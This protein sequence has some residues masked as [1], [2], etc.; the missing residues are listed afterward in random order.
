M[1]SWFSGLNDLSLNDLKNKV[2]AAIP[3]DA[4]T[5][6]KLTLTTPELTAEREKI[7]QEEKRKEQVRD[8]L[9]HMYPWETRDEEREILVEECKEAVMALSSDDETFFGPYKM[10]HMK[11]DTSDSTGKKKKK[12]RN[13]MDDG[14][15][16]ADD[17]EDDDGVEIEE[18]FDDDDEEDDDEE[19]EEDEDEEEKAGDGTTK[20]RK[21]KEPTPESLE[22]LAKLEPLPP[23]LGD[24]DLDAHVGLIQKMLSVD[25]M[26]VERQSNLSGKCMALMN[27]GSLRATL[28]LW[29]FGIVCSPK[30]F[31]SVRFLFFGG[32]FLESFLIRQHSAWYRRLNS[33]F[34]FPT[35]LKP[36]QPDESFVSF[37]AEESVKRPFGETTSSIVPSHGT[38][39]VSV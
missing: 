17:D 30:S 12:K 38:K 36:I 35:Q 15:N 11:V 6:Q 1:T 19:E 33:P 26:L 39:L 21:M 34:F 9:A 14:E 20:S 4:E 27:T 31:R 5:I 24:F 18:E 25:P 7:D 2:Q 8:M 3:I 32:L 37:Q 23:L 10:P 22:K 16:H 28:L 29:L 13:S